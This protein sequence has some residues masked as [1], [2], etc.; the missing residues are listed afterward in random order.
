[1]GLEDRFARGAA[2]QALRPAIGNCILN[3]SRLNGLT[4][5][6]ANGQTKHRGN[7]PNGHRK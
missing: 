1:M 6:R 4:G 7:K 2:L 5:K 3:H